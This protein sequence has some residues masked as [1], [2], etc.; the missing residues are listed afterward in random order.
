[1]DGGSC[2]VGIE[3][4]IIDCTRSIATILRPGAITKEMIQEVIQEVIE[5]SSEFVN[6]LKNKIKA[7]G[8]LSVHY[9]PKAQILLSGQPGNGDGFIALD[10][11]S[12]PKG[13]IR[14]ASPASVEE[15]AKILYASLRSADIKKISRIFIVPPK[16]DGLAH[17][18]NDRLKKASN[19]YKQKK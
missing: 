1:L 19:G 6:S 5:D 2:K 10:S 7:S 18:I 14:L 16:G 4:T 12:T 13:S 11:I 17:A 8:L 15:Y 3:S 9:S